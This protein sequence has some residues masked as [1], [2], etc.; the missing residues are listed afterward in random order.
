MTR[1]GRGDEVALRASYRLSM[2]LALLMAAQSV[3]GLALPGQ[4]RDLGYVRETWFGNDLVTLAVF[5]PVLVRGLVL[6]SE[7]SSVGR[8]L[9]MGSLGY[10]VYND[11]FYLFGA[12]LNPFFPLYVLAFLVS[13]IALGLGLWGA[14][15]DE[16]GAVSGAGTRIVG[17]YFLFVAAGL[18]V[19][20]IGTWAAHV[21]AGRPT[22]VPPEAF[23][24]IAALDL[25]FM[26]PALATSG[27]LLWRRSSWGLVLGAIAGIQASLYLLVLAVNAALFVALAITK[28]PGEVPIWG[29]L[30]AVTTAATV[31][32]LIPAR[33]RRAR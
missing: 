21:F 20:W 5:L 7:G 19:V 26:V 29:A 10:A 4:Y 14:D 3:L 12:A 22:P 16:L 31:L 6:T 11:A 8:L 25:T 13:S 9:W 18:A 27:V 28:A 17:A 32:L 2:A 15:P 23:R 33:A 1:N 24:L 30:C